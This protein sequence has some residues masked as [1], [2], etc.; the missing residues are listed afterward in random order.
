MGFWETLYSWPGYDFWGV[1]IALVG[2]ATSIIF[3]SAA[4]SRAAAA[5][6]AALEAKRSLVLVD[7]VGQL[8]NTEQTLSELRL[9]LDQPQWLM[10]SEKCSLVRT[11]L[12]SI[13]RGKTILLPTTVRSDL[14]SIQ[15]L[16]T[17]LQEE[18]DKATHMG[19]NV[20][21]VKAKKVLASCLDALSGAIRE[22]SETEDTKI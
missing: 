3:A 18:A 6:A 7:T 20:D 13:L 4:S 19:S 17:S 9:R 16:V 11:T 8:K 21:V 15:G 12:A 5:K 10:F 1:A 14:L 22:L 2:F